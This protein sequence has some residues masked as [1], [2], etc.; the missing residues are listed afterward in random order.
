MLALIK[1]NWPVLAAAVLI[2]IV[3]GRWIFRRRP[4]PLERTDS[5]AP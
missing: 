5:E 3:T 4:A 1:F 2:G